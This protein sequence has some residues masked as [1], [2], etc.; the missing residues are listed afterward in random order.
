MNAEASGSASRG[1]TGP[2][3]ASLIL[4]MAVGATSAVL[5]V[6]TQSLTLAALVVAALLVGAAQQAL[7]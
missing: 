7:P 4:A 3:T 1:A 6:P 2:R 5:G